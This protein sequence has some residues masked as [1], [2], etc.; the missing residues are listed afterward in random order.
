MNQ[1]TFSLV[2][3]MIFLLIAVMHVLRHV[4]KWEAVLNG[5]VVPMS[6]S[7]L[8]LPIAAYLAFEGLRLSRR[9]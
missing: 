4:F 1:K 5:W 7:A 8:A 2:V 9:S 6:V 3:G